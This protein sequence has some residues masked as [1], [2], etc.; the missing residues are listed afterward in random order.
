MTWKPDYATAAELLSYL[1]VNA[2]DDTEN[3]A[4]FAASWVTAV[5]RNIDDHTGRQFGHTDATQTR[6]YSP[7]YDQAG[8]FWVY[9]I[10]DLFAAPYTVADPNGTVLLPTDFTLWPRNA[11]LNGD[12]Y[13]QI[14]AAGSG[15]CDLDVTAPQWGW[16]EVPSSV[17]TGIFLQGARLAARRDSPFGISGSP[18]E[19]GEIRLLAQLDPDFRTTL[20][21]YVRRWWAA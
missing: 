19:Q 21:P 10:D 17:K 11:P 13:T 14:R 5:S 15:R 7:T 8:R 18:Q 9:Q 16:P 2:Q 3:V 1:R 4:T 20:K 12:P 6:T